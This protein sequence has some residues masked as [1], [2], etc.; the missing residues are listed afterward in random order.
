M[1]S[2]SRSFGHEAPSTGPSAAVARDL[3]RRPLSELTSLP[4]DKADEQVKAPGVGPM[5]QMADGCVH[6]RD[7]A[8]PVDLPDDVSLD[9]WRM[10]L[11]WLPS[12]IPGL[13]P[14]C[15]VEG[16]RLVATNQEW[17]WALARRSRDRS[18]R[19]PWPSPDAP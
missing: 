15:R 13:M 11:D 14:K 19:W 3:S 18:R 1:A 2:C 10:L 16:L 12:G 8:R 5:G 17:S 9:D 4:R 6:L 7:C